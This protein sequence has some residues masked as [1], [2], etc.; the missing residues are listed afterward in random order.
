MGEDKPGGIVLLAI[1]YGLG[2]LGWLG[3]G[4]MLTAGGGFLGLDE[5]GGLLAALGAIGI[6]IGLIYFLIAWGLWTLKPWARMMAIIFAVIGLLSFPVG[7]V[8]SIIILWY[9][10]K[11][12]IKAAF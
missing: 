3:L 8:I 9:L 11:P 1:L 6:I 10:F 7:T 12:E 2:G 4:G 5:G